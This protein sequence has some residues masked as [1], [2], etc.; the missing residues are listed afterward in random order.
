MFTA[1]FIG[2]EFDLTKRVLKNDLR[3]VFFY[4]NIRTPRFCNSETAEKVLT[5]VYEK[6]GST[7]NGVLIYEY[8]GRREL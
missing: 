1:I 7:P 2:G 4:E 5:L 6:A 3:E 8:A